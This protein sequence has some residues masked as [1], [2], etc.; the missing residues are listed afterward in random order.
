MLEKARTRAMATPPSVSELLGRWNELHQQGRA[1]SPEALCAE[2]PHLLPALKREIAA[3]AAM[4]GFLERAAEGSRSVAEPLPTGAARPG[5]PHRAGPTVPPTRA[6]AEDP[7]PTRVSPLPPAADLSPWPSVPGYEIAAE[8]GRGGMGVV[9]QARQVALNRPVAL[10]MILAGD[11]AGEH[12]RARFRTEAEAVARL[13]HPNIVQIY[14]VGAHDGKPY[15]SLEFCEG[16]NLEKRLGGTPLPPREAAG[17]VEVLARAMAAAHQKGIIHRDLKPANVLL[18]DDGTLKVTDFGLAKKVGEAGQTASGAIMGTPSYM[19]P[20]QAGGKSKEVGPAADVY[21]LGAILYECLTGRPPFKAA[22]AMDTLLQVLSEE[23]VPPRLLQP[24][25]PRDLETVCLTCLEKAPGKR[26]PTAGALAEDLDRYL[27]GRPTVARPRGLLARTWLWCHHRERVNDAGVLTVFLIIVLA[28]W[29]ASGVLRHAVGAIQRGS[30]WP[31]NDPP[32]PTRLDLAVLHLLG[33]LGACFLPLIL[34]GLGTIRRRLPALWAGLI[35][36][37]ID[38]AI[39]IACTIGLDS[40]L[41]AFDLADLYANAE[42]RFPLFALLATFT[43][44]V[45]A[46]YLIALLAYYSNFT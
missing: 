9:Y 1:L 33:L 17:L 42:V 6:P 45:L 29:V 4:E 34:T 32:I 39:M 25:T 38:L 20:E 11:Y 46:A 26:Y 7:Y 12:H 43:S 13:R 30:F 35:V 14:E 21:A 10:K 24:K 8:L 3:V 40:V 18:A 16:G 44:T 22:T 41:P 2:C 36:S 37:A 5:D 28:I 19:A 27:A 15:F 31:F 23:P